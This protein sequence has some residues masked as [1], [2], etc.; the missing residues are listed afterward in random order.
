M[1]DKKAST[2]AVASGG[3]D[4]FALLRQMT[5]ELDRVLD[6]WPALRL[7]LFGKTAASE[8]NAWSPKIDV[9]ERD[10]R[11]VI[12]VDLPGT[13]KEDVEVQ[14]TDGF[15]AVSGERK[16]ETEQKKDNV[17]RTEREYGRFY[18]SVPLA[19]GVKLEDVKAAFADGIL[20]VSI[21]LPARTKTNVR[22]VEIEESKPAAQGAA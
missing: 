1:S 11:L 16:R 20:E 4:P 22:K 14:V 8:S 21:P 17:Y 5:S 7:P 9:F 18:R 2:I 6:E 15:L 13:K 12:R 10:N 19:E 3:L